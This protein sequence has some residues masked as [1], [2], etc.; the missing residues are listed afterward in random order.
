MSKFSP[1]EIEAFD[2]DA[3][4]HKLSHDLES[5]NNEIKSLRK[6]YTALEGLFQKACDLGLSAI[7]DVRKVLNKERKK[8]KEEKWI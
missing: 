4:L 3:L 5:K 2:K 8:E 6:D 7:A 1:E